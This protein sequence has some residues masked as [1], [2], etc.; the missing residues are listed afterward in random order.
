[1][2]L[3]ISSAVSNYS[4][5]LKDQ[6]IRTNLVHRKNSV[7]PNIEDFVIK[8]VPSISK[9]STIWQKR[10]LK[11]KN[12][13]SNKD[14]Y[15]PVLLNTMFKDISRQT[16]HHTITTLLNDGI[17]YTIPDFNVLYFKLPSK[18]PHRALHVWL[19]PS[20]I[21]SND[22]ENIKLI[23]ELRSKSEMYYS[24]AMKAD[25]KQILCNKGI[26]RAH[27]A[28]HLLK[29]L[30]GDESAIDTNQTAILERLNVAIEE[31]SDICVDFRKN[32]GKKPKHDLFWDRLQ[33]QVT[34]EGEV[35]VNMANAS[36]Y[37][38]LYRD[39]VK[40][41]EERNVDVPS[42]KWFMLQF[43][44]CSNSISNVLHYTGR[45]K[46]R[47]M[48]QSRIFRK[49]NPDGHY[50]NA[51]HRFMKQRALEFRSST[52]MLSVDAKCKVP[53]GEPNYPIAAVTRG[54]IFRGKSLLS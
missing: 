49:H 35:I 45:F 25:V 28:T 6:S 51:I 12:L 10:F 43:W 42:Y 48:V 33:R 21:N 50:T 37:A 17:H 11:L 32:N 36:S 4:R 22:P 9:H 13:L 15:T 2:I 54:I 53:I 18:G 30:L 34:E 26:V 44:P 19:Q 41:A 47:K 23:S 38:Q 3:Q 5:Y 14:V 20:G 31:G 29:E 40:I 27:Q 1:M 8:N 16:L 46:V 39:C 24:R 7:D 52:V